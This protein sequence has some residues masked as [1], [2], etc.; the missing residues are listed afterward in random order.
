MKIE[1]E[2]TSPVERK[3]TIE[4]D[5]ER[6]GK[7]L[8][9]AYET[10]SRRVKLKGFRPGKVPRKVL[11]RHFR[12]EVQREVVEKLVTSTLSDAVRQESIDAVAPPRVDVVQ[13]SLDVAQPFRFT[14]RLEVKPKL[15]PKD[16]RGIEVK[17]RPVEVTDQM[18][19]DE[20]TRLQ[21]RMSQ[22]VPV[23]G[24]FDAMEGDYAVIDHEGTIGGQPFEGSDA[25]GVNARVTKGE[26]I[27]GAL[28]QL[29]GK[30]LGEIL[31]VD[32]AFPPDYR[33]ESLRGKVAHFK[34]TLKSLKTRRIPALDDELAK[35]LG[36]AEIDTL[37]KLRARVRHDLE[38][39]ETRRAD[40]EFKD[41]LVKAALDRND[42]EVP[43]AMVERAI[44]VMIDRTFERLIRQGLD[45]RKAGID[46]P[47]LRV[48]LRDQALLQ[49][50]G[51]LLLDAI[52]DA[53]KIEV[54]DDEVQAD[55]AKTAAESHVPLAEVQQQM[56]SDE[57]R[58]ALKTRLR[59]DKAL[60][61]LTSEAK[62]S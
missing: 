6:V 12:D 13:P 18:I 61:F 44:D 25:Q 41:A 46:L 51:A 2:A 22:L 62:L 10:L 7:E 23:E 40:T 30:K 31:E 38:Q 16:Y 53:E 49:V 37:E 8:D 28:P 55:I 3:V 32:T 26:L 59:E 47:K 1:V 60:A 19:A 34:V 24:R 50:K 33:V 21:D 54:S 58:A 56:R 48:D 57:A 29:E 36:I 4:V 11:E 45:I 39:Q 52:A 15:S 43:P 42:F 14:A 20:F 35:D 5:P 9:R 27:D 17:R